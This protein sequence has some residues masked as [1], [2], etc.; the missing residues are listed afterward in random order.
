MKAHDG[1]RKRRPTVLILRIDLGAFPEQQLDNG[2]MSVCGGG[3][4]P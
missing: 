3:I 2:V 4:Q 1:P